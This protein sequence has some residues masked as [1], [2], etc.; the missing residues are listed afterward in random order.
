MNE[1]TEPLSDIQSTEHVWIPMPDGVRLSARIWMPTHIAPEGVPAILEYIPYRKADMVR[2][3]DERNHPWFAMNG[4]VSLRVDMRGSGDS[5]GHMADMYTNDELS[6]ARHVIDWIA[7]QSWCNGRVGMFGTSW[8]GTA[9]LQASVDAP[10]ALKAIIAV[11]ATHDRYEDDIH[12]M[13]GCLLTDTFEWGAT[14][15]AILALPPTP[16]SGADWFSRWTNRLENLPCPVETWV[17]EEAR[18]TYWRHGSVKWQSDPFNCPVLAVG[19]WSDRYSNSVMSLVDASPDKVWGIV[20]P[21]GHHYPDKGHPGPAIGFQSVALEWWDHWLKG[22]D[23]TELTWPRLRV[24]Q[25]EF[26]QPENALDERAGT[27]IQGGPTCKETR[28]KQYVLGSDDMPCPSTEQLEAPWS[29]PND[30]QHGLAAGDTGF[31]GRF[32]GLPLAQNEDDDRALVFETE[33]LEDDLILYG[34]STLTLTVEAK[35]PRSQICVRLND[36]SPE[37]VSGLVTFGLANLG[38]DDNLDAPEP[39]HQNAVRTVTIKLPTQAYRFRRGHR[40]RLAIASSYWPL[41]WTPPSLVQAK[42]LDGAFSMPLTSGTLQPLSMPLPAVPEQQ[43][44]TSYDLRAATE[45]QRTASRSEDGKLQRS[46][47]QP[48]TTTFYRDISTEFSFETE[49]IYSV[50]ANDPNSA[51]YAFRLRFVVER[52]DGKTTVL[53]RLH[54]RCSQT[55]YAF[56][57]DIDV[58]W[59]DKKLLTKRWSKTVPRHLS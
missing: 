10:E 45:L 6:D 3:R 38:L 50:A 15:P 36:V 27:W 18:G 44:E 39:G 30:L 33:V 19:G 55:E 52:P 14:L 7:A 42:V 4:Y 29:I 11:C 53:S 58:A 54:A 8:G 40:I 9:S 35:D 21:W 24:W 25:R 59:K 34:S 16:A 56:S 51:E 57:C 20:G 12:H 17:Q 13:G 22:D 49:A 43:P 5:E 48:L 28:Q 2:A 26:D 31:F 37:G 1:F 47:S 23:E 41:V 32:G 46:W